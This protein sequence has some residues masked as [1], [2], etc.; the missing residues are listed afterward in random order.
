MTLF[1][2]SLSVS[3]L[4][5]GFR[6]AFSG[7]KN[8][9]WKAPL[10]LDFTRQ[11]SFV[12]PTMCNS[13]QSPVG[14]T[15]RKPVSTRVSCDSCEQCPLPRKGVTTDLG[16]LPAGKPWLARLMFV[17]LVLFPSW[18]FPAPWP[19]SPEVYCWARC[20][21]R[22]CEMTKQEK[23]KGGAFMALVTW[24][25]QSEWERADG[26]VRPDWSPSS[27]SGVWNRTFSPWVNCQWELVLLLWW[28]KRLG[29]RSGLG[30]R[31]R[32]QRW[33]KNEQLLCAVSFEAQTLQWTP[34]ALAAA[35]HGED[36][37]CTFA[38][39]EICIQKG[40]MLAGI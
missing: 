40:R 36:F 35:L 14:R 17:C 11:S 39:E 28:K 30:R 15:G 1:G 19:A 16:D 23:K 3:L 25:G 21:F 10:C 33:G 22:H 24:G 37:C 27:S 9:F 20:D 6:R 7:G 12:S 32:S 18:N 34:S 31:E 5:L 38:L 4:S 8:G 29:L 26:F 13:Y 2:V